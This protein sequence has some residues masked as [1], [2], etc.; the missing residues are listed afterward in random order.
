MSQVVHDIAVLLATRAAIKVVDLVPSAT[1]HMELVV[2]L[3]SDRFLAPAS[4]PLLRV[5]VVPL[6]DVAFPV[7][8]IREA[9]LAV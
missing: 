8:V 4:V 9:H 3:A 1:P 6:A 2:L 7:P 5:R